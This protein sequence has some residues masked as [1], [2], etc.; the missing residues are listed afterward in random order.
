[1][2]FLCVDI[3]GTTIKYGVISKDML[4][5]EFYT[6]PT[7]KNYKDF[8]EE[9]KNI[10]TRFS[11]T[12]A[13][14]VGYPGA[15]DFENDLMLYA[16]NLDFLNGRKL[17]AEIAKF[18]DNPVFIENDANLAALGEYTIIEQGAVDNMLFITLGTGV[19]GG[20]IVN[21]LLFTGS[22]TAF[23]AGHTSIDYNGRQC[24]CGRLGCLETYCSESGILTT[25]E[26]ISQ[27]RKSDISNLTQ[28]AEYGD[29]SAVKTFDLFSKHLAAGIADCINLLAPEKVKIG[30][31]LSHLHRFFLDIT[32]QNLKK[33]VYPAYGNRFKLLPAELDNKAGV[34]GAAALC[35]QR[36]RDVQK[37]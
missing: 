16:P 3:G 22:I 5:K 23:E 13:V 14:G 17:Q 35:K 29:K 12:K 18:I 34:Y 36:Y 2:D 24:N 21:R 25:F 31:G 26:E 8:L 1:M 11:H 32:E 7:P 30:G 15:Y 20:A 33:L 19:G 6:V 9:I 37:P 28:L 27:N 10:T 4:L